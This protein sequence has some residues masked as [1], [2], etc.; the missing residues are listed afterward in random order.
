MHWIEQ[1][2]DERLDPALSWIDTGHLDTRPHGAGRHGRR[3]HPAG[4]LMRTVD[5]RRD[6]VVVV[7]AG[8]AGL[9]AALHLAGRGRAVTVVE[10]GDTP[11]GGSAGSTSPAIASTPDRRC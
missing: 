4:R 3:L 7:G 2:I 1:L 8:L 9:S 6:H 5:G 10:R 11:A